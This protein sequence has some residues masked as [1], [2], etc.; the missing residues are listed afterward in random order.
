MS[1]KTDLAEAQAVAQK[2]VSEAGLTVP[3]GETPTRHQV[4]IGALHARE[5][6]AMLVALQMKTIQRLDRQVWYLRGIVF[7]LLL[8]LGNK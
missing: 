2:V 1:A 8:V 6:A 7:L 5:D 3:H 4:G